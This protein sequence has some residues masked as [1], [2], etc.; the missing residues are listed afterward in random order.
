MAGMQFEY[1][2]EGGTFF[3]F[4]L[5]FWALLL[6]PATYFL[7]PSKQSTGSD[8]KKR[9]CKCFPCLTKS[10]SLVKEKASV[11]P[12]V[13]KIVLLIGW[14]I[15]ILLAWK[16][17]MIQLDYSEYDPYE[18]LQIDRGA[19][20]AE[21]KKAYRKLSK[22]YHPDRE[23]GDP[24]KFMRIAKAYAALT[25]EESRKNWE[26][27]GNPDGPEATRF[28]I[29]LPKWIVERENSMWVLAVYGLV[30]MIILPIVVGVWW[31]RSIKFSG[32][33]VLLE[34]SR[35][36]YFFIS[37][38]PNMILK[39]AV[40]VLGS[41]CEFDRM[42]NAEIIERPTDNEELPALIKQLQNVK[43][44]N[45]ERSYCI[46]T[47]ALILAHFQRLP[48][49][50]ET[51]AVDQKYILKKCPYLIN[52]MVH[53][54]ANLV[55]MAINS[56]RD[57]QSPRLESIENFM[58]MSQMVVQALDEKSSP[59]QQ[60][61][62]I[63]PEMLRHFTTRKR[64][65]RHIRDFVNMKDEDRRMML[66][67]LSD[68]EYLD[69][70]TV[71]ANMP[72]IE[73]SVKTEVLDEEDETITAGS[74]V[75]VTV[76]LV[77]KDMGEMFENQIP[78]ATLEDDTSE[79]ADN[80]KEEENEDKED[81]DKQDAQQE[82]A[83]HGDQAGKEDN[84]NKAWDKNKKAKKK[85]G[86]VKKKTKQVYQWKAVAQAKAENASQ[87][88]GAKA[89]TESDSPKSTKPNK[90]ERKEKSDDVEGDDVSEEENNVSE[91]EEEEK[92]EAS[93]D[94]SKSKKDDDDEEDDWD[95]Y[96]LESKKENSLETKVKESHPVHC[97]YFP[98][99]KQEAW[100]VYVADRKRHLLITVPVHVCSLK[101][102]EKIELKFSAPAKPGHY[103]YVVH[104]RSDSYYTDFDQSQLIK[105]DVHE[106]K[107]IKDHPQWNISEDEDEKDKDDDD[108]E[109]DDSDYSSES[110]ESE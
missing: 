17:S 86:K 64:D 61:P 104:L 63:T 91:D 55:A 10:E 53:T 54:A 23:T 98:E 95:N 28:G 11:K 48:L 42:H 85:G 99:V 88:T 57:N 4:L 20:V 30:F 73:M 46:K 96:K 97:P 66:R 27:Y 110:N 77:R 21:I 103:Q 84:K 72:Y 56:G 32:D 81:E 8:D 75:T 29:A 89:I 37:R 18:E 13:I 50:K 107:V 93:A 76:K 58:K 90:S 78:L 52:E 31:Y 6:I 70:M 24:K 39:R 94:K 68:N 79:H 100:W 3:Y 25:D 34:T 36:Y 65:I 40:E 5:S 2:A 80:D 44:K 60:L 33:Q 59:L 26:E 83:G 74:I 102:E 16:V 108:S 109:E 19:D 7:W 38:T 12:V 82:L 35:I 47:R 14:I 101:T 69:V 41:S 92:P 49:N 22:V 45:R 1:D 106:A 51:L 105:L 87:A 71:C 43:E 9:K 15:F 62:H 67:N